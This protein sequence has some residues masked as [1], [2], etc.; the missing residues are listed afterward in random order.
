MSNFLQSTQ[1]RNWMISAEAK[2]SDNFSNEDE[3]IKSYFC[4]LM[5]QTCNNKEASA[6]IKRSWRV[7]V[8]IYRAK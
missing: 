3:V 5:K 6:K 2:A 7:W 1:Y 4:C 8:S